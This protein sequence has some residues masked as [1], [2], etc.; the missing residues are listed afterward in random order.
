MGLFR[1]DR[2]KFRPIKFQIL[3]RFIMRAAVLWLAGLPF[4]A[5]ETLGG[6]SSRVLLRDELPS[7]APC[8]LVGGFH[9]DSPVFEAE[10]PDCP[11]SPACRLRAGIDDSFTWRIL[12]DGMG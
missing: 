7:D 3:V 10:C 12:T 6:K 8:I 1:G 11:S 5:A 2:L 4:R 9:E